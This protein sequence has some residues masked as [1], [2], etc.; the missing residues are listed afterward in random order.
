MNEAQN[1]SPIATA[2]LC[3]CGIPT[4]AA[5]GLCDMC[6]VEAEEALAIMTAEL[7]NDDWHMVVD[8]R[9]YSDPYEGWFDTVEYPW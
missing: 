3:P 7:D 8:E 2:A 5:D 6:A 1:T 9:Y 4:L